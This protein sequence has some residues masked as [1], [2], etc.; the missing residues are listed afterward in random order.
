ML[1]IPRFH[2]FSRFGTRGPSTNGSRM[3]FTAWKTS[4]P[5]I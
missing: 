2:T 1:S 5:Q 4:L 3:A